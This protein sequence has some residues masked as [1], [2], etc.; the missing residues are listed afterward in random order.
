MLT[1]S[2][3]QMAELG[4]PRRERFEQR[5]VAHLMGVANGAAEWTDEAALLHVRA[6][7]QS[8]RRC[9]IESE[10]GIV[11]FMN[12]T[13]LFGLDFDRDPAFPWAREVLEEPGINPDLRV[14][15]LVS[16]AIVALQRAAR[17][18]EAEADSA[19]QTGDDT[20]NGGADE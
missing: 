10:R 13:L 9:G 15:L 14:D 17:E 5:A 16:E 11:R 2:A 8:A 19:D 4:R 1:I 12:L 20:V 7:H 6:A 18:A 3:R